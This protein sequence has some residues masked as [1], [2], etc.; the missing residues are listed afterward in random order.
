MYFACIY[1]CLSRRCL[2][3]KEVMNL[4]EGG[5]TQTCPGLLQQILLAIESINVSSLKM[6]WQISGLGEKS[7]KF[8]IYSH[9]THKY[10]QD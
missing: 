6:I 3:P 8:Q 1:I 4:H 7:S 9:A 2:V 5:G 10:I